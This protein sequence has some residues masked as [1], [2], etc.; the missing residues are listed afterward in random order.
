MRTRTRA[1]AVCAVVCLHGGVA[2][3]Q[4]RVMTLAEVLARARQ[5]APQIVSARLEHFDGPNP[6]VNLTY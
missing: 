1:V 4:N 2:A 6:L 3:A 5:Q